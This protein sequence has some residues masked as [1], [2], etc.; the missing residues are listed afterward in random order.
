MQRVLLL[1][2]VRLLLIVLLL[3]QQELLLLLIL[4]LHGALP[5]GLR[6]ETFCDRPLGSCHRISAC[7]QRSQKQKGKRNKKN[8][9]TDSHEHLS[10]PSPEIEFHLPPL[11]LLSS[12]THKPWQHQ[13]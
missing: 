4:L 8:K 3:L 6:R 10:A 9:R 11:P 2:L 7:R 5:L 12:C 13:S 1:L